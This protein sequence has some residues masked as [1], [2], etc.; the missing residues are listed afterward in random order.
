M[1]DFGEEDGYAYLVMPFVE[2]GTLAGLMHGQPPSLPLPQIRRIVSQVGEA[3][4]YAHSRGLVHRDVKPN[5]VLIDESGNSQL[6][7]FGIAKIVAKTGK[8]TQSGGRALIR[9]V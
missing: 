6:T 3:L 5:N 1:F 2:G 9:R 7:D 8:F 4:N